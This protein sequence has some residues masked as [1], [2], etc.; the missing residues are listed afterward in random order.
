MKRYDYGEQFQISAA[1]GL[2][3]GIA[4]NGVLFAFR[5]D[6]SFLV[7]VHR[8]RFRARTIVGFT[9]A[10][11]LAL[12]AHW[13]LAHPNPYTGGTELS[14]KLSSPQYLSLQKPLSASYAWSSGATYG[15]SGI[16]K[17]GSG[18]I[19]IANTAALSNAG[20]PT[21]LAQPFAH[22]AFSELATG[23]TIGKGFLEAKYSGG[24]WPRQLGAGAGLVIRPP[25]AFGSGGTVRLWVDVIWSEGL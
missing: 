18:A 2:T 16:S 25:V 10:Q 15:V 1:S 7:Y 3:T 20:S 24:A 8:L 19:M 21:I 17:L 6:S 23:A 4:S 9:N 13:V 22:D 14:N 12:G 5:N 11:E